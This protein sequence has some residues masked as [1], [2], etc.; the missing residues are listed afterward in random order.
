MSKMAEILTASGTPPEGLQTPALAPKFAAS[1]QLDLRESN[2]PKA[3]ELLARSVLNQI[4]RDNRFDPGLLKLFS[5]RGLQ[6]T[7]RIVENAAKELAAQ[8]PTYQAEGG[9][10]REV[11]GFSSSRIIHLPDGEKKHYH[12]IVLLAGLYKHMAKTEITVNRNLHVI[13]F[14]HYEGET[15]SLSFDSVQRLICSRSDSGLRE[16]VKALAAS[17][18]AADQIRATA[19]AK[20]LPRG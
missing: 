12:E 5:D 2:L 10:L 16:I 1:I 14:K 19:I 18:S 3:E 6:I 11:G 8:S 9:Q 13:R 15:N 17:A 7:L 20:L 4:L